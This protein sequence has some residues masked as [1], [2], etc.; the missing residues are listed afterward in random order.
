MDNQNMIEYHKYLVK[1]IRKIICI[2]AILVIGVIAWMTCTVNIHQGHV[3]AVYD[4]FKKGI[5]PYTLDEGLNFIA[6]W[7]KV[8]QFP[9]STEVVYMSADSREGSKDDES[10]DINCSDGVINADLS[11]TYHFSEKDVPKVQRK[12]RGK[13]GDKIMQTLR[14]PMRGWI[15]EI[16]KNYDTM[17]VHLTNKEE[18]NGKL[19]EHLNKK[20]ES[21]GVVF[22]NITIME[23]RP[24]E[25]VKASIEKRQ[26][27]SQEVEQK[28]L[29][30]QKAE[31][32]KQEAQLEADRKIIEAEGDRKANEIKAQ[33]L[34]ERILKEKA[35]EAWRE[36]GSQ[37]PQAVGSGVITNLK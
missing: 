6:P 28:K 19:V 5:Q 25:K 20:A 11:Y 10:I 26:Q 21:Y 2:F 35:I 17:Q 31:I 29:S 23:T 33:G 4:R 3:G 9:I 14:G 15:S 8:N 32:Q 22:E 7:Q 30:L 12:Y 18:I 34:D 36:G 13:D 16:T 1:K 24:S 27:I 37:V